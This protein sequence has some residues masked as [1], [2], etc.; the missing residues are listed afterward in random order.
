[1]QELPGF[2]PRINI[3]PRSFDF[4]FDRL[5]TCLRKGRGFSLFHADAA[6]VK[7][8]SQGCERRGLAP[9]TSS[10]S[11][12]QNGSAGASAWSASAKP[13]FVVLI[14][15]L[16][17]AEFVELADLI[18]D[19]LVFPL[20]FHRIP[21]CF[22]SW[23]GREAYDAI[24]IKGQDLHQDFPLVVRALLA[25]Q[26]LTLLERSNIQFASPE[27]LDPGRPVPEILFT[28]LEEKMR[29]ALEAHGLSYQPQVRLGRQ[30]VDFLVS[31]Q[32][33]KVIVE[34]ESKP[35]HEPI[36][37]KSMSLAGYPVCRFSGAEIPR[38]SA[39]F[40]RRPASKM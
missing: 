16:S 37:E 19:Q 1:M 32:G 25:E 18:A 36:Q 12:I 6:C 9:F 39:D 23:L 4:F 27:F 7:D 40:S 17:Y 34:C 11:A 24:P 3:E 13:S 38:S 20:W 5:D 26:A 33:G 31:V 28:A 21:V 10:L 29:A 22:F 30:V 2:S 15:D 8:F 35:H 14:Q